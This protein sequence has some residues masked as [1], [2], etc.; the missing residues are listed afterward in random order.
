MLAKPYKKNNRH[1][2]VKASPSVKV[3]IF[4]TWH[5]ITEKIA[6]IKYKMKS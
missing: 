3:Y 4:R 6:T 2:A 1:V 5:M